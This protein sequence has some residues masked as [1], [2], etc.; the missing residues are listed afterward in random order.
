MVRPGVEGRKVNV[1]CYVG[2]MF[3]ELQ[4][5]IVLQT[6][7][8]QIPHIVSSQSYT[9]MIPTRQSSKWKWFLIK[10]TLVY[11]T[12]ACNQVTK[13]DKGINVQILW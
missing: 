1:K 7:L 5:I 8:K 12:E 3:P 9:E 4:E 6:L 13:P 11:T 2:I 10:Q